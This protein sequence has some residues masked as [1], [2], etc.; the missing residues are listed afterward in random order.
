M[1]VV[2]PNCASSYF[3]RSDEVGR[4]GRMMRCGV[5]RS[6]FQAGLD[7]ETLSLPADFFNSS[8]KSESKQPSGPSYAASAPQKT[9]SRFGAYAAGLAGLAGAGGVPPGSPYLRT[10]AGLE[11]GAARWKGWTKSDAVAEAATARAIAERTEDL[12]IWDDFMAIY[13]VEPMVR[14]WNRQD[15]PHRWARLP[16]AD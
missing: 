7:P 13:P 6:T 9:R 8:S 3:I 4:A 5:C 1:Q 11:S 15:Y 16:R 10:A 12:K 2:C 14:R